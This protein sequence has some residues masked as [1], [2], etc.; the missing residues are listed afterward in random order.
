MSRFKGLTYLAI[1]AMT[2]GSVAC[3]D[4][5]TTPKPDGSVPIVDGNTPT[6]DQGAPPTGL[7]CE[8]DCTDYV[9]NRLLLP[10]TTIEAADY[11]VDFDNDGTP[12][13]ALGNIISMLGM[14][15]TTMDVQPT[16]DESVWQGSALVLLRLKAADMT[17]QTDAVGQAWL[18]A[19]TE[20]CTDLTTPETCKAQADTSCFKGDYSFTP[21]SSSPSD[22][23]FG[24]GIT[25]GALNLGPGTLQIKLPIAGDTPLNLNLKAVQLKATVTADGL[26]EGVLAGV[27]DKNDLDNGVIPSLVD[28]LNGMLITGSPDAIATIKELFDADGDNT[29]TE[30]E[31]KT[32]DLIEAFLAGDVDV[33]NDGVPELSL[34]IGF[35]AVKAVIA[36]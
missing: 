16:V 14:V 18:A 13:N 1:L 34:G 2:L 36:D 15:S 25:G 19:S 9:F 30:E 32:N 4:D 17:N 21:D 20:C 3:S 26:T 31:L 8:G 27:I 28:L 10:T 12:D 7:T 22:A 6:P 11:A 35:S 5:D 29:I 24:G 23:L 33:D